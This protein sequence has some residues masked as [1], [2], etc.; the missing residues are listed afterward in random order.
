M[1]EFIRV[2]V[3]PSAKREAVEETRALVD[4]KFAKLGKLCDEGA[5]L[6]CEIEESIAA[7]RAGGH[8]RVAGNLAVE[9]AAFHAR[10]THTT[11]EG[12][13][14]TVRNALGREG[15]TSRSRT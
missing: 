4:S 3:T 5:T 2:F 1:S 10:A 9:G 14:D 8:Y 6:V 7:V 11:L 15:R 12:A 13:I